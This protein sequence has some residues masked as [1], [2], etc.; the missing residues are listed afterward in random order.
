[1]GHARMN[2]LLL[3]AGA[4]NPVLADY[5]AHAGARRAGPVA[6]LSTADVCRELGW[7][8]ACHALDGPSKARFL[9]AHE[10]TADWAVV[11]CLGRRRTRRQ[12]ELLAAVADLAAEGRVARVCLVGTFRVHFGDRRAVELEEYAL[13]RLKHLRAKTVLLRPG[14]VLSA[15]APAGRRL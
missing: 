1:R 9:S 5:A 8:V 14:H 4:D 3:I 2:D 15:R 13:G 10:G 12:R 7:N 6:V 11:G